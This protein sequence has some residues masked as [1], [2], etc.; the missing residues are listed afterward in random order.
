MTLKHPCGHESAFDAG[1]LAR[2]RF[3]CPSCGLR[4]QV[5]QEPPRRYP[6]GWIGPGERKVQILREPAR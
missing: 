5:R 4:W 2:D 1:F 6:S 3:R